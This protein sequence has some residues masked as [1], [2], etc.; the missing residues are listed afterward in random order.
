MELVLVQISKS[1][2]VDDLLNITTFE[3]VEK[4]NINLVNVN[5]PLCEAIKFSG[6]SPEN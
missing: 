1:T 3:K 2:K 5:A 6:N 4:W